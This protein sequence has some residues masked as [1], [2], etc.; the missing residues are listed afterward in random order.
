MVLFFFG[1]LRKQKINDATIAKIVKIM[2]NV[3]CYAPL[4]RTKLAITFPKIKP[5]MKKPQK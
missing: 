4:L 5:L 2:N 3:D 1:T